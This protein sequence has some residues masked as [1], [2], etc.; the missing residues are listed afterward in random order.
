MP[1]QYTVE[2]IDVDGDGKVDG[3]LVTKWRLK[4]DGSKVVVSHKFVAA[5]KMQQIAKQVQ[6]QTSSL[7][8]TS[9]TL[10]TYKG[11]TPPPAQTTL[12]V[13]VQGDTN[14]SQYIKLGAG[15]EIG[16]L[17]VDTVAGALSDLF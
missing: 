2:T 11:A 12:P 7:V 17:A 10:K 6:A 8:K 16:R 14:F 5:A 9:K 4:K 3:D 15:V 13:Q 1:F